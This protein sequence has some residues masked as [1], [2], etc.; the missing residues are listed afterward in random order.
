MVL[1]YLRGVESRICRNAI[2]VHSILVFIKFK[3]KKCV[4]QMNQIYNYALPNKK[5][6]RIQKE[7]EWNIELSLIWLSSSG[8]ILSTLFYSI[9]SKL[10]GLFIPSQQVL[11]FNIMQITIFVAQPIFI[12]LNCVLLLVITPFLLLD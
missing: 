5:W 4:I 11:S 8:D 12:N 3:H 9:W 7:L 10:F 1:G 2:N 6:V